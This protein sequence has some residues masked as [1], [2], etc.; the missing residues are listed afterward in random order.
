MNRALLLLGLLDAQQ[1]A[2]FV[3]HLQRGVLDLEALVQQPSSVAAG[4]V[5]VVAGADDHV[6]GQRREARRDLPHVQVVDLGDA[7]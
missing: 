6:R 4:A 3:V 2:A 1:L 7:G 5:A